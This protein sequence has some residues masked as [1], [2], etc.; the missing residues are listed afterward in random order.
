LKAPYDEDH[1]P[2]AVNVWAASNIYFKPDV[3]GGAVG[4]LTFAESKAGGTIGKKEG[5]QGVYFKWGSLI[6]VSAAADDSDFENTDYLFIPDITTGKY[7]KV[8]VG[9]V[10]GSNIRA[11]KDFRE[12]SAVTALGGW[13]GS[14]GSATWGV[15]PYVA[16][17]DIPDVTDNRY[18]SLLTD[19]SSSLRTSYKGDI[20]RY[21]SVTK[22]TSGSGLSG[23]NNWKMPVSYMFGEYTEYG[24][25]TIASSTGITENGTNT[26]ISKKYTYN[27]ETVYFPFSGYRDI[28]TGRLYLDD[29]VFFAGLY[30]SSSVFGSKAY[31]LQISDEYFGII[32]PNDQIDRPYGGSVRCVRE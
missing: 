27:N 30:W 8:A 15:I 26:I 24:D 31:E 7:Y 1:D 11:V 3:D 9:D 21:L 10:G 28:Y 14:G 13:N 29:Y 2:A 20:C 22:S 23:K 18:N 32:N 25:D 4:S 19:Y 17:S 5:Y 6:G 16:D 12:S